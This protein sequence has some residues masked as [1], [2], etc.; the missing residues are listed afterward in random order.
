MGLFS[1]S[2]VCEKLGLPG[3]SNI[4]ANV[5]NNKYYMRERM[6]EAGMKVPKYFCIHSLDELEKVRMDLVFPLVVKPVDVSGSIGVVFAESYE[7][8]FESCSKAL[9][10][11]RGSE[12]ILE[13]YIIGDEYSVETLSQSGVHNVIAITQKILTDLP[14]FVESGHIIPADIDEELYNEIEKYVKQFLTICNIDN[15][16]SHTEI[17]ITKDGPMIIETGARIGGDQI[18]ADLVPLATGIS[19]H[20]NIVRIS[21]GLKLN[22]DNRINR[23]AGIKFLMNQDYNELTNIVKNLEKRSDLVRVQ[24]CKNDNHSETKFG[25]ITN[26]N[27]RHGYYIAVADSKCELLDLLSV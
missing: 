12:V 3:P 18:T 9:E 19:M 11:S 10:L 14:Y 20:E 15:S 26:S 25:C 27:D 16:A 7:V 17:R 4:S 8:V 1:V 13:E 22:L 6:A 5:S 2:Y 21:L 24:I 23:Y